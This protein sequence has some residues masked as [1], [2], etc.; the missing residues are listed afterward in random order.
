MKLIIV[1]VILLI[2][3]Y[4]CMFFNLD[5]PGFILVHVAILNV[6]V[7]TFVALLLCKKFKQACILFVSALAV[8]IYAYAIG[9][10]V[11]PEFREFLDFHSSNISES[12]KTGVFVC[13]YEL[14]YSDINDVRFEDVFIEYQ[15]AY[16]TYYSRYLSV[17]RRYTWFVANLC[18]FNEL[19]KKGYG[20]KWTINRHD[21]RCIV[22]PLEAKDTLQLDMIDNETDSVIGILY[23]KRTR[24]D[25]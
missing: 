12:Q 21:G 6:L 8:C 23:L 11:P 17:D 25:R 5:I 1:E 14:T 2:C 7:I 10:Q 24:S 4:L 15:H 18:D 9:L 19:T 13:E 20:E 3:T 16:K 22:F